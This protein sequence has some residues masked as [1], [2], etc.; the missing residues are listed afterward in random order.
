MRSQ[1]WRRWWT[2]KGATVSNRGGRLEEA[3]ELA[4]EN[5]TKHKLSMDGLQKNCN[6]TEAIGVP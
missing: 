3:L 2:G 1:K 6:Q 4:D 5:G